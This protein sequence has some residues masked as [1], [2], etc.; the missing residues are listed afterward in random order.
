MVDFITTLFAVV[1]TF[2]STFIISVFVIGILAIFFM[3]CWN[4]A[5]PALFGLATVN[6]YQS[7]CLLFIMRLFFSF[8]TISNETKK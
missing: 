3:L 5:V 8:S 1:V 7:F 2:I 6:Y 4:Y